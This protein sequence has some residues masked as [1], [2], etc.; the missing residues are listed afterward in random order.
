M[1]QTFIKRDPLPF[2]LINPA[3][4]VSN[5]EV[6]TNR[7]ITKPGESVADAARR[8]N[9]FNLGELKQLNKS[10]DLKI[11]RQEPVEIKLQGPVESISDDVRNICLL[12]ERLNYKIFRSDS[13]NYN[14][15]IVGI[16]NDMSEPNKFDDE[17]WVFWKYEAIWKL[18]KYKIT[19]DPGLTYLLDPLTK[20]GTAILKEGQYLSTY[21]LGKHQGKYEALVQSKPVT[22]IR[23]FNRDNKLDF[24]SGK[25]QTGMFGINIHKSSSTGESILV[26]KWS[27]GCQVFA[28]INEYN[29]FIDL[30]KKSIGEWSNEFTY[31]LI[32]KSLFKKN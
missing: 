29:E 11:K 30:C 17:L 28:R 10:V 2:A 24:A 13:K 3:D 27:A 18:K 16:R 8:F 20:D 6:N 23:D 19:T 22:V 1:F 32:N 4:L 9:L 15:N 25:E 26:N 14:L 21:R 31:T 12:M 5:L 7:I